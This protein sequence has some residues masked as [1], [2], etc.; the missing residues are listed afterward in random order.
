[1]YSFTDVNGCTNTS[2]QNVYVDPAC[3]PLGITN[4]SASSG[5]ALYP[6]P[7]N[8]I[9]TL[10]LGLAQ[11][12]KTELKVMNAIGQTMLIENHNFISGNNKTVLNLS[13]MDRGVYFIEVKTSS[14]VL[15]Q[16]LIL[17]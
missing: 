17:N 15:V 7:T 2:T 14:K 8:G 3:I 16:R 12:E 11:D 4:T 1:V 9:F 13:G 5:M 6:N 10:E